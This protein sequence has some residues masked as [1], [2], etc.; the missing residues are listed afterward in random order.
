MFRRWF[1][2][3]A[4]DRLYA[5]GL[6]CFHR[7][8][9]RAAVAAFEQSLQEGGGPD[10]PTTA[11]ASFYKAE[12]HA[13]LGRACLAAS[14]WEAALAELDEALTIQPNF[15]DLHFCGGLGNYQLG[16]A[17]DAL[18][19]A[20][21]ALE[22]NPHYLEAEGLVYL[23]HLELSEGL[24]A[25]QSLQR[26]A[27]MA[28]E[29]NEPVAALL[30]STSRVDPQQLLE[31]L[32]DSPRRRERIEHATSL[33]EQGF[34]EEARAAF[35]QLVAR[36]PHYPDLRVNLAKCLYG[37]SEFD[38][39]REQLGQALEHRPGL[40]QANILMG[41]LRLAEHAIED[42]RSCFENAL[43]GDSRSTF[44][45]YGLAA[46]AVLSDDLAAAQPLAES[47]VREHPDSAVALR[48]LCICRS[49]RHDAEGSLEILARWS[50]LTADD[51]PAVLDQIAVALRHGR[52]DLAR[53]CVGKLPDG[54][55]DVATTLARARVAARGGNPRAALEILQMGR[56]RLGTPPS[57]ALEAAGLALELGDAPKAVDL[58]EPLSGRIARSRLLLARGL[59]RSGRGSEAAR[60][61][62]EGP[63]LSVDAGIELLLARRV[64]TDRGR[65]DAA[66]ADLMA[67]A[68]L[69]LE[70]RVHDLE[71]WCEP[72]Q[73]VA[74]AAEAA[75]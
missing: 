46:T 24:L 42:A 37:L 32:L 4:T 7:G 34:W 36:H 41:V 12:A 18:R 51:V 23:C 72:F 60:L 38:A 20:R 50:F 5:R 31:T 10:H 15:P 64:A 53:V 26:C 33:L 30:S 25:E 47:L 43:H 61:L 67:V 73:G 13:R 11:L 66:L 39:A 27:S 71:R 59:R 28:G 74:R 9:L 35:E 29:R 17:R 55:A 63:C 65:A 19:Y 57:L 16:R 52:V 58:L 2:G 62:T 48:L 44:A 6:D 40:V 70:V 45:R 22:F 1:G 21:R 3:S 8:E 49:L 54:A 69:D 56:E 68:P 14:E 75:H